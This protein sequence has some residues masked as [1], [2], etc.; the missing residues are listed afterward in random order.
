M[1]QT[2]SGIPPEIQGDILWQRA[3]IQY[4]EKLD[5]LEWRLSRYRSLLMRRYPSFISRM[6]RFC[7]MPIK[8]DDESFYY[9]D[10]ELCDTCRL[11]NPFELSICRYQGCHRALYET[12]YYP[13]EMVCDQCG[14][15]EVMTKS[16]A[17]CELH[18]HYIC[19]PCSEQMVRFNKV[20][21]EIEVKF[22]NKRISEYYYSS[23]EE[24]YYLSD[25]STVFSDV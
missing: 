22:H 10:L 18:N 21:R 24:D 23:D 16:V 4:K 14:D 5:S 2:Q 11:F 9:F 17:T 6:C 20:I 7:L 15:E 1:T 25:V 19:W 8:E 13:L 12:I 3:H